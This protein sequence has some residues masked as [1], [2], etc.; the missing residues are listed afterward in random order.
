M[1]DAAQLLDHSTDVIAVRIK[2]AKIVGG[3]IIDGE[4]VDA[5][6]GGVGN[7]DASHRR[8]RSID[9]K[10]KHDELIALVGLGL[11]LL[12]FVLLH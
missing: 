4:V 7:A 5:E 12:V 1:S 3:R 9:T 11:V 2:G 10:R 8:A 6:T